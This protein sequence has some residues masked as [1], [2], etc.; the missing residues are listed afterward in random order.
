MIMRRFITTFL[1]LSIVAS[2][3]VIS[4]SM[5]KQNNVQYSANES[6]DIKKSINLTNA[7]IYHSKRNTVYVSMPN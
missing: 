6:N 4:N 7:D 2:S 3:L 5:F 1:L